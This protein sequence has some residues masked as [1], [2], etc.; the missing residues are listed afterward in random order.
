[1]LYAY[2]DTGVEYS[3]G[4]FLLG[5]CQNPL[6]DKQNRLHTSLFNN[7][8]FFAAEKETLQHYEDNKL[9]SIECL[10]PNF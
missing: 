4:L 7:K 5:F 2:P 6:L 9:L 8:P 3:F 1:M 10:L